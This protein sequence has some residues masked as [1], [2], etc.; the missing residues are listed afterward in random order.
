MKPLLKWVGGKTQI[1]EQVLSRFPRTLQNYHEPFAGGGS[2]F[3][4]LLSSEIQ[5]QGRIY[6]SD[7]NPVLINFYTVVQKKPEHLI[8]CLRVL[9]R[10]Y[11][12]DESQENFY[13]RMRNLFNDLP[14]DGPESAAL[15]LFLNKT[16]FR[17]VYREGPNGYNV[18]F[19]H[20]KKTDVLDETAIREVSH[21]I[22]N[23]VFTCEGFETALVRATNPDDFVYVDPPYAPET[24]TSFVGYVAGGFDEHGKLFDTLRGLSCSFLMSNSDVPLVRQAFPSPTYSTDVVL[25]RRAIHSRDPST[26]TREVLVTKSG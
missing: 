1:L 25:A 12:A 19:G 10:E 14:K 11:E 15:F 7:I 22:R 24:E 18:P 2:V 4:G 16:G 3:L 13:Y 6:V 8:E 5:V 17:G 23:V 20:Y 21:V 9:V 26:Q